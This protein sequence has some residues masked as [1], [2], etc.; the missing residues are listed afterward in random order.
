MNKREY[1][2]SAVS[3]CAAKCK[4]RFICNFTLI[5]LSFIDYCTGVELF[6]RF[7]QFL[8]SLHCI[9][10]SSYLQTLNMVASYISNIKFKKFQQTKPQPTGKTIL[11]K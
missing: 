5:N 1:L 9:F 11:V 6:L 3:M 7:F 10:L 4:E 2:Y 8:H